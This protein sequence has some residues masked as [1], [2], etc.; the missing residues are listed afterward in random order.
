[1][2]IVTTKNERT[3]ADVVTRVFA[4]EG[5]KSA[6]VRQAAEAALRAANPHLSDATALSPGAAIVVPDVPGATYAEDERPVAPPAVIVAEIGRVLQRLKPALNAAAAADVASAREALE[7]VKSREVKALGKKLPALNDRL[8]KLTDAA[9]A[10]VKD[11]EAAAGVQ[12][13]TIAEALRDLGTLAK[14]IG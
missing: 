7:L 11:A 1:M 10:R 5:D 3:L 8:P 9:A 13:E 4:I 12:K 6:G 14:S 2:R